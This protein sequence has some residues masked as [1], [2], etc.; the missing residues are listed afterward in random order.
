MAK[1]DAD[2]TFGPT[3]PTSQELR[4]AGDGLFSARVQAKD[5][6]A[7]HELLVTPLRER[8]TVEQVQVA[9]AGDVPF[10]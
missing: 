5:G 8:C 1:W 7:L 10:M 4:Q 9:L 3:L 6:A 2:A